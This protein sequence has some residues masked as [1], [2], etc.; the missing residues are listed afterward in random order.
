[1]HL[2]NSLPLAF[3][4]FKP[5]PPSTPTS[6]SFSEQP[7]PNIHVYIKHWHINTQIYIYAHTYH[8]KIYIYMHILMMCV[9]A[10][11]HICIYVCAYIH[12]CIYIFNMC[13]CI[14]IYMYVY[15]YTCI[16]IFTQVD[17]AATTG[18]ENIAWAISYIWMS[19]VAQIT[20]WNKSRRTRIFSVWHDIVWINAA[21][22]KMVQKLC[23]SV[24]S[25]NCVCLGA[26]VVQMPVCCSVWSALKLKLRLSWRA[27]RPDACVC[28]AVCCS[29]LQRVAVCCSV[30]QCVAICCIV[31]QCLTVG[32]WTFR[33]A[34]G[35]VFVYIAVWCIVLQSFAVGILYVWAR[36]CSML[37][38]VAKSC[39][40][41]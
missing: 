27:C 38:C 35:P 19:H 26:P 1:M 12:I 6:I 22:M 10:Y 36:L 13:V 15:I 20:F 2:F 11:I 34:C 23:Q 14:H 33:W 31:F 24:P 32:L 39:Q 16:C 40:C 25:W 41:V 28:V 4:L 17:A 3:A 29:V 21:A 9:C 18:Y 7:M 30:L 5:T 37:W 8:V